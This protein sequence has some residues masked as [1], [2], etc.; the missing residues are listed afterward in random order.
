MESENVSTEKEVVETS[1]PIFYKPN[2]LTLIAS[3]ANIFSWVTLVAFLGDVIA[4]FINIRDTLTQQGLGFD[5]T[6]FSQPSALSF[7]ISNL[8][9]PL[10]TGIALF[11]VL[12]GVSIGLNA[13][14]E[15]DLNAREN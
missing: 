11:L 9:T 15:I 3:L 12:Q 2:M 8:S 10:F 1:E 4:Q 14:Y 7:L 5:A 6:L 13:L